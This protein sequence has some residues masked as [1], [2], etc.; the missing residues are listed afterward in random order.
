MVG[1][2]K[3]Y[4]LKTYDFLNKTAYSQPYKFT[5]IEKNRRL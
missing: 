2:Q 1:E 4:A 3:S 5:K